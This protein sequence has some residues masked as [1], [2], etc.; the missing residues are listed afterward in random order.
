VE[1]G[2]GEQMQYDWIDRILHHA[3]IFYINGAIFDCPNKIGGQA[4][5]ARQALA[6]RLF[7]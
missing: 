5:E 1:R 3:K 6:V 4:R 7:L 2:P